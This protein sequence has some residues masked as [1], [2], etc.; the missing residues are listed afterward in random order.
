MSYC[1]GTLREEEAV[2]FPHRL[3]KFVINVISWG[4]YNETVNC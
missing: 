4:E 1:G 2:G 3:P